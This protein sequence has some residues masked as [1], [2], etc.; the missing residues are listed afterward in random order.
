MPPNNGPYRDGKGSVYEGGTRVVALANRPG[1][2][3]PGV[4]NEMMHVVDMYPTFVALAGGQL[5]Q[6]K[7]LD[8]VDVWSTIGEGKPTPRDEIV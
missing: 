6:K 5:S 1:R 4:V 2:I 7:P 8:G 3:R